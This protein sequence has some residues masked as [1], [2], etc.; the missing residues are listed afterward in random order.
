MEQGFCEQGA[1]MLKQNHMTLKA[2]RETKNEI[3][4]YQVQ[5][6][7]ITFCARRG[8]ARLIHSYTV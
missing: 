1:F 2:K 8:G 7:K 3:F 4:V 5:R 6:L